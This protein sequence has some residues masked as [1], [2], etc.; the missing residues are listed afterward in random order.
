MSKISFSHH[1]VNPFPY[2]RNGEISLKKVKA[3]HSHLEVNA[4]VNIE[5]YGARFL[6]TTLLPPSCNVANDDIPV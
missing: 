2:Q 4:S 1:E 5:K 3:M 6:V